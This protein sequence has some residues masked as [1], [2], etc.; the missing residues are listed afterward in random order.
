LF[1]GTEKGKVM[2]D[3]ALLKIPIIGAV[4]NKSAMSRFS[5]I[6]GILHGSGVNLLDSITILSETM[7]NHAISRQF[8]A[9]RDLLEEGKGISET[10]GTARYFSPMLI[11]MMAIGEAS[12][13]LEEMLQETAKHYDEEVTYAT[14]RLTEALGPILT[15]GL[16]AVIGF[17]AL[18]VFLPMWD[19]TKMVK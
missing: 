15:I 9:V 1:L 4:I 16:A 17:F 7:R 11:N 5:N 6:F 3:A 19:L 14:K 2:K 10:F 13:R 8:E 12:G 18:A